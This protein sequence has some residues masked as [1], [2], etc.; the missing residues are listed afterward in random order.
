MEKINKGELSKEQIEK[1]MTCKTAD[2]L[3]KLAK[4]EG[5]ELTKDEAKEFLA[6]LADFE[7]DEETLNKAAGGNCGTESMEPLADNRLPWG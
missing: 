5:F 1:A 4:A 3:M 2:E 6:E 7:L